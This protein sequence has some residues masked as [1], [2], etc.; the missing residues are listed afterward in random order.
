MIVGRPGY[1]VSL[2][3]LVSP[4][5]SSEGFQG[6]PPPFPRLRRPPF[7]AG[8][9]WRGTGWGDGLRQSGPATVACAERQVPAALQSRH[10]SIGKIDGRIAVV[11][12]VGILPVWLPLNGPNVC[13]GV[14]DAESRFPALACLVHLN[15]PRPE[16]R[17]PPSLNGFCLSSPEARTPPRAGLAGAWRG[18]L[19]AIRRPEPYR[20]VAFPTRHSALIEVDYR[21]AVV[22]LVG[23]SPRGRA[24]NFEYPQIVGNPHRRKPG[25]TDHCSRRRA[26]PGGSRAESRR[27]NHASGTSHLRA[28]FARGRT[29][30]TD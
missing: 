25:G 16:A 5:E 20:T 26:A 18:G 4:R 2:V 28:T 23:I 12:R 11:P 17:A 10:S 15:L 29:A 22:P 30:P 24:L 6:D 8:A 13:H 3:T 19:G 21:G 1:R 7:E 27:G 14:A 9:S